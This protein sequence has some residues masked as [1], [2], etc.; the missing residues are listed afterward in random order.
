MKTECAE[1]AYLDGMR[2]CMVCMQVLDAETEQVKLVPFHGVARVSE[3]CLRVEGD[4]GQHT[5]V[6]DCALGSILP[7][8]GEPLLRDAEHYVIVKIGEVG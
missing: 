6:P 1:L 3:E 4:D 5:V 2:F 8:D 7:N